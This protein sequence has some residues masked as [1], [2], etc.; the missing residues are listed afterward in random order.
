MGGEENEEGMLGK[1][2]G[3]EDEEEEEGGV[4]TR[5]EEG[6]LLF[7]TI[8][9]SFQKQA[10]ITIHTITLHFILCKI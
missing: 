4:R 3:A 2:E 6:T 8:S 1:A 10:K 5:E 9:Y 7:A